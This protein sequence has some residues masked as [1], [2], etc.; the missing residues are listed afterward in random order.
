MF[1]HNLK[2]ADNWDDDD[3][4]HVDEPIEPRPAPTHIQHELGA[5][6][7]LDEQHQLQLPSSMYSLEHGERLKK[8]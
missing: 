4:P 7:M 1:N 6:Q 3:K 8:N 2:M 5:E